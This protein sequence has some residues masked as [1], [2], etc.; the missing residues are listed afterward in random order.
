M[1][2]GSALGPLLFLLY[3]NDLPKYILPES[4]A[5]LSA[6]DCMLH[7]RIDPEKDAHKLQK[8]LDGLQKWERHWLTEFHPQKCQTIHISNKRKH[9]TEPYTIH[10]HV[11][12]EV[13]TAKYQGVKNTQIT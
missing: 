10:G 6:D 3:I 5:P 13:D 11:L 12:E 1:P 7:R 2:Q 4:V 9:I 8:Y